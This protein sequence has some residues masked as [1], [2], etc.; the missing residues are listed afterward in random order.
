MSADHKEWLDKWIEDRV[1][2]VPYS[3]IKRAAKEFYLPLCISRA[4]EV[5]ITR[6]ELEAAAGG[7][8]LRYLESAIE[9]KQ[10]T[11]VRKNL[12]KPPN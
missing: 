12:P 7:K 8:L 3:E 6:R 4:E 11:E 2:G 5:G 10:D 9:D 1:E